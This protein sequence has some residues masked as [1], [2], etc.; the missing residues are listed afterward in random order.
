MNFT[1]E[2]NYCEGPLTSGFLV[3]ETIDFC[4]ENNPL[5]LARPNWMVRATCFSAY[6]LS[7]LYIATLYLIATKYTVLRTPAGSIGFLLLLG[8]KVYAIMFYHYMEFTSAMPPQ[9]LVAY[10]SV[11]GPYIVSMLMLLHKIYASL[12]AKEQ[13][14]V[15][16]G[17]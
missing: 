3:Q 13:G 1:V 5:F 12:V 14:N 6:G 10:F 2:R 9:N 8:M 16:K 17:E 11:E 4:R 7:S 15:N